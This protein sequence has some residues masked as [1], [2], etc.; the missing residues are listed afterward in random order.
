[1][2]PLTIQLLLRQ[3]RAG[4]LDEE[5]IA[6]LTGAPPVQ[7]PEVPGQYMPWGDMTPESRSR[8]SPLV[9]QGV[10]PKVTR[11]LPLPSNDARRPEVPLPEIFTRGPEPLQPIPAEYIRAL[12]PTV[13]DTSPFRGE[14]PFE[15][16][17][18]LT[19]QQWTGGRSSLITDMLNRLGITA[20]PGT[21][22]ANLALQ[23]ALRENVGNIRG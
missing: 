20:R 1:M 12:I 3:L 9:A 23:K 19:G 21:A 8:T 2:D 18:R 22:A 15:T 4:R 6:V 5:T 13:Q 16:F 14:L 17:Q 11:A 7:N 10:I